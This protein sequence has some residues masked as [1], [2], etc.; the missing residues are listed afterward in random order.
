MSQ[1][2][3]PFVFEWEDQWVFAGGAEYRPNPAL[4]LRGGYNHAKSPVPDGTLNPLFPAT[5][6]QHVTLGAGWTWAANTLNVA[7]ERAFEASQTNDGTDPSRNP[8]GPGATVDHSQW[9]ISLGFSRAF[10]SR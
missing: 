9:T 2:L 3:L 1:V 6:R 8:F 7:V 10:S 4:T 5:T